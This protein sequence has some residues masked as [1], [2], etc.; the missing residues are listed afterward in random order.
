MDQHRRNAGGGRAHTI[1][2]LTRGKPLRLVINWLVASATLAASIAPTACGG[3]PT[4]PT[5]PTQDGCQIIGAD[6]VAGSVLK[7][8]V[9]VTITL[10]GRCTLNATAIATVV[11]G[12][13]MLP[14]QN[15]TSTETRVISS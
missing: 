6:P 1:H 4:R 14:S 3:G 12:G 10:T 9:P 13:V 7:P 15:S 5:D 2:P 8:G 11:V